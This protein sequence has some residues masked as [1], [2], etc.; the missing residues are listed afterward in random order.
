MDRGRGGE[1]KGR[2]EIGWKSKER[3]GEG[4]GKDGRS[5]ESM[6]R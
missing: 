4:L 3:S 6:G 1:E 5:R 2:G